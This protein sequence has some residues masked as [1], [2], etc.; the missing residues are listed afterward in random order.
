[1]MVECGVCLEEYP[2]GEVE[3]HRQMCV[4]RLMFRCV[5]CDEDYMSKEG[6]WNHLDLHEITD[7]S[8]ELHY[9]E[10][11]AKH[12]LHQCELCNDQR[13][14]L[15]SHYWKHVQDVHDGFFLRCSECGENFRSEKL[16]NDHTQSHCKL[17]DQTVTSELADRMVSR[18]IFPCV[19]EK[20]T[21]D[22]EQSRREQGN[23]SNEAVGVN[24]RLDENSPVDLNDVTET[25]MLSIDTTDNDLMQPVLPFM[26]DICGNT[27]SSHFKVQYHKKAI[28]GRIYKCPHCRKLF[29]MEDYHAHLLLCEKKKRYPCESCRTQ[30]SKPFYL[31]KHMR[32][33][34]QVI[35]TLNNKKQDQ[36]HTE[37][38]NKPTETITSSGKQT[39]DTSVIEH[40]A[41]AN[42]NAVQ[43]T[44][45]NVVEKSIAE[46]SLQLLTDNS[47]RRS[48]AIKC[49][50]CDKK[51]NSRKILGAHFRKHHKPIKCSICGITIYG[52]QKV[53]YHKLTH[54][55][56][57]YNCATCKKKFGSKLDFEEHVSNCVP[58]QIDSP[59]LTLKDRS[60]P[61]VAK[62][63][64]SGKDCPQCG[65]NV[66]DA[67]A[68]K[69][70]IQHSHVPTTCNICGI[71]FPSFLRVRYHKAAIHKIAKHKCP[72]CSKT[73]LTEK[74]LKMHISICVD[75]NCEFCLKIFKHR[76][77]V[78]RHQNGACRVKRRLEKKQEKQRLLMERIS[79]FRSLHSNL[80]SMHQKTN[81]QDK[82][83]L[84]NVPEQSLVNPSIIV[85]KASLNKNPNAKEV[86]CSSGQSNAI[87]PEENDYLVSSR[88][89]QSFADDTDSHMINKESSVLYVASMKAKR[90]SLEKPCIEK[91]SE[92]Q[93]RC[94]ICDIIWP[95]YRKARYHALTRHITSKLQCSYCLK[96]FHSKSMLKIH[97][98]SCV[99]TKYPCD[100]CGK[101]YKNATRVEVHKILV[102]G[103]NDN[104]PFKWK[105]R[106][107]NSKGTDD[108]NKNSVGMKHSKQPSADS[109]GD[110]SSGSSC[111]QCSYCVKYFPSEDLLSFHI[112]KCHVPCACNICGAIIASVDKLGYHKATTHRSAKHNCPYCPLKFYQTSPY[113]LHIVK[114]KN[115]NFSCDLCGRKFQSSKTFKLHNKVR[116]QDKEVLKKGQQCRITKTEERKQQQTEKI[117]FTKE[118]T[119]QETKSNLVVITDC[120]ICGEN[121]AD[122]HLVSRHIET[123]HRMTICLICGM[124]FASA[125]ELMNHKHLAKHIDSQFDTEKKS[126][127]QGEN[128]SS[129]AKE[130]QTD[131]L[132]QEENIEIKMEIQVEDIMLQTEQYPVSS[133][134]R[135]KSFTTT[136]ASVS[137]LEVGKMK[138]RSKAKYTCPTCGKTT[139]YIRSYKS[140][141]SNCKGIP[142]IINI[143]KTTLLP[144]DDHGQ[145]QGQSTV[146]PSTIL[147]GAALKKNANNHEA[148]CSI[149]KSD[150]QAGAKEITEKQYF[151]TICRISFSTKE[152]G[153]YHKLKYH[154][155]GK[156]QCPHCLKKYHRTGDLKKH[157][158]VCA[159]R[160]SACDLCGKKVKNLSMVKQHMKRIHHVDNSRRKKSEIEV[161]NSTEEQKPGRVETKDYS[162]E[163]SSL[164]KLTYPRQQLAKH[165]DS[166]S[167]TEGISLLEGEHSPSGSCM[168]VHGAKEVQTNFMNLP[169]EDYIDLKMEIQ[170]EDTMLQEQENQ[171]PNNN[172]EKSSTTTSDSVSQLEPCK[173]P[174][175]G[176]PKVVA[177]E[178]TDHV[179]GIAIKVE[180]PGDEEVEETL[181]VP[182]STMEPMD[183]MLHGTDDQEKAKCSN[184][185]S[186]PSSELLCTKCDVK[187]I[188]R[189]Q[190]NC[191]MKK[192]H[193]EPRLKCPECEKSFNNQRVLRNHME[194]HLKAA[195]KELGGK[196]HSSDGSELRRSKR[197]RVI[198]KK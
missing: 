144:H 17:R 23:K 141:M 24:S 28:H 36:P 154:T 84:R 3:L 50:H 100:L 165:V 54:E 178:D 118:I 135:G 27:F 98:I 169:E 76:C 5:I 152:Q 112:K 150:T 44:D 99:Q 33:V 177:S 147:D 81:R 55:E 197:T 114:C 109:R 167:D 31:A 13:A 104:K 127:L 80:N 125:D 35:R 179:T 21:S 156:H 196:N 34:H 106:D 132:P 20:T 73:F 138:C 166:Q 143:N 113:R 39:A 102:H 108:H 53:L 43:D 78:S 191:H 87:V 110:P 95:S 185:Y 181:I 129:G 111:A 47:T 38:I 133:N 25:K 131:S 72:R 142:T 85:D 105:N 160:K 88:D 149:A 128:L 51:Y 168:A 48:S 139:N 182:Q 60:D 52:A 2:E 11:K 183:L 148:V 103:I 75:R 82:S 145:D 46:T 40:S 155:K 92:H 159:G 171:V 121:F 45:C 7:E 96:Q 15:K 19:V 120:S 173:Q 57:P 151:C 8:K 157:V 107:A 119:E 194:V 41:P 68:L 134:D 58:E 122:Q 187:F 69:R 37:Q 59:K 101:K 6:L 117:A 123:T 195:K 63:K 170:A 146:N 137:E 49:D 26:C 94:P 86:I 91:L 22:A 10:I 4:V 66:R 193:T 163:N 67:V 124:T 32:L 56:L 186:H 29:N 97:A 192:I 180:C 14:Y 93:Y 16:K 188:S 189:H 74:R 18:V 136:S 198:K 65:K 9:Q 153:K 184:K 89:S 79:L 190:L 158:P 172:R 130:V 1:M 115:R 64:P 42:F 175:D 71:S 12:K 174:D 77:S 164:N 30:F 126:L 61:K 62:E 70:H 83:N 161:T 162:G 90:D 140:H 176:K 116:H